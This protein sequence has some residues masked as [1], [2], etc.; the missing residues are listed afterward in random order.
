ME[1]MIIKETI[2]RK[3][4]LV[5]GEQVM[6]SSDLAELYNVETFR[7]NEAVKRNIERFPSD[8]MFQ[9]NE[10][11]FENWRSQFAISNSL[12]KGLRYAPY[13]FTEQGIAIEQYGLI[14]K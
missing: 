5:R 3:I 11:E 10:K 12:K 6:L 2:E 1:N 14:L 9:M 8:F 7:L 4:Y 13:A